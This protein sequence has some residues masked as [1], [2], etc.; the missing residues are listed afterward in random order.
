M[1]AIGRAVTS[2]PDRRTRSSGLAPTKPWSAYTT[3]PGCVVAQD[4]DDRGDVER[5]VG[6]DQHLARQHDLLDRAAVDEREDRGHVRVPAVGVGQLRDRVAPRRRARRVRRDDGR[7]LGRAR[8]RCATA[9]RRRRVRRCDAGTTMRPPPA[10]GNAPT[11]RGPITPARTTASLRSCSIACSAATA[12]AGGTIAA[13]P[14]VTKSRAPSSHA[15]PS[16]PR[17][18]SSR[19]PAAQ[20]LRA[21]EQAGPDRGQ[22]GVGVGGHARVPVISCAA[23]AP[24]RRCATSTKPAAPTISR[25][26]A[27]GGQVR[28]GRGEVRVRAAVGEQAADERHDPPEPEV[29]HG[30]AR[31]RSWAHPRRG[32]RCG[33][34]A[35]A[36]R[37]H[38]VEHGAGGRRSSAARTRT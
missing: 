35:A 29:V 18:S 36:T 27:R 25:S 30:L 4:G 10:N 37:A 38:S 11:A 16:A 23:P 8:C 2:R 32:A 21:R 3:Q 26:C 13:T 33:R 9:G 31:A 1:P 19:S 14:A 24:S 22:A 6:L 34:A 7:R 17:W 12:S 5:G 15:A 28:R 20:R